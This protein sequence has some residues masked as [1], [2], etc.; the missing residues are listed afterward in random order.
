MLPAIANDPATSQGTLAGF[1]A[2][3]TIFARFTALTPGWPDDP[4]VEKLRDEHP[5][6]ESLRARVPASALH[7][8]PR[9]DSDERIG[10]AGSSLGS[11]QAE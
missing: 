6:V 10:Q 11:N 4:E 5:V 1:N 3:D 7:V 8:G 9:L 2:A